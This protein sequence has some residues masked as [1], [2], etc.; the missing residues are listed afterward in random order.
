MTGTNEK[1]III[2]IY[3]P[4]SISAE[5]EPQ[6]TPKYIPL[7]SGSSTLSNIKAKR[8]ERTRD[9]YVSLTKSK[10]TYAWSCIQ[11][12]IFRKFLLQQDSRQI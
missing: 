1:Y 11:N 5:S 12:Y 6:C 9:T 10:E 8:K 4:P 7:K 2:K 3:F